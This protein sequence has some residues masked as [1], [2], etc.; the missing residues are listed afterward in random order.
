MGRAP[1]HKD[2]PPASGTYFV[3]YADGAIGKAYYLDDSDPEDIPG[4]Y[5]REGS[6][7]SIKRPIAEWAEEPEGALYYD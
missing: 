6:C 1:W 5:T 3:R 2:A 7:S 4:Y